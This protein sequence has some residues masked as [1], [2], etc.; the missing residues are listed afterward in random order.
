VTSGGSGRSQGGR[1]RKRTR[2]RLI[3]ELI[4]SRPVASQQQ[5]VEMLA[6]RGV[7]ITQATASR[8]I[9]ELGL[10]KVADQGRHLYASAIE[11]GAGSRGDDTRLRRV[12]AEYPVRM[13]RSGLTL[14]LVSEAGTAGAIGQAIDES[15]LQ[16]QEGTLAGDNTTLVLFADEVRLQ[17]WL[18]RFE[19]L[20][21][22]GQ[23]AASMPGRALGHGPAS[24]HA[25]DGR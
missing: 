6:S 24:G 2:H 22:T 5:L 4:A 20:R 3:L 15:T 10:V 1:A 14:L 18:R 7:R 9:A 23:G 13:G 8:D 12:L 17:T 11:L 25:T 21:S 16:E 19:A